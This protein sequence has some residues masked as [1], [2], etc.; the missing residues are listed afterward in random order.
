MKLWMST[1]KPVKFKIIERLKDSLRFREVLTVPI[2][3]E[4]SFYY[5]LLY[6]K[7][8]NKTQWLQQQPP[9]N[10]V[11]LVQNLVRALFITYFR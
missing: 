5:L 8:H 4:E 9:W 3:L 6:N 11:S 7:N 2:N 10:V 1:N